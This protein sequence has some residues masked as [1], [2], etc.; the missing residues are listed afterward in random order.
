MN[1]NILVVGLIILLAVTLSS[2]ISYNAAY[3]NGYS[4]GYSHGFGNARLINEQNNITEQSIP[5]STAAEGMQIIMADFPVNATIE[6]SANLTLIQQAAIGIMG[7]SPDL[8]L[9]EYNWMNYHNG[10]WIPAY[11][12]NYTNLYKDFLAEINV[13]KTYVIENVNAIITTGASAPWLMNMSMQY[14]SIGDHYISALNNESL[15]YN[16]RYGG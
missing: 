10:M 13:S 8:P 12:Y 4:Q 14:I 1:R 2:V 3:V 9:P 6:H 5:I 15:N 16:L 11:G 7:S